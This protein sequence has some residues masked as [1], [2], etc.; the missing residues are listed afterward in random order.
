VRPNASRNLSPVGEA[1][2]QLAEA[3]HSAGPLDGKMLHS[4]NSPSA[5]DRKA[6]RLFASVSQSKRGRGL[7]I[8]VAGRIA[9]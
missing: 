2:E 5:S 4:Q 9:G 8:A 6:P 7:A 1:Y 3:C